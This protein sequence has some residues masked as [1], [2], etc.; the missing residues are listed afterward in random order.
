MP[1]LIGLAGTAGSGKD[2]TAQFLVK[3]HGFKAFAFADA[4][5]DALKIVLAIEDKYFEYPLKEVVIQKYG[6][7]AR[8][9]MQ[10][11]GTDWGRNSVSE[12]IWVDIAIN[13]AWSSLSAGSNVVLTDVRFENEANKIRKLGGK[14]WHIRRPGS[15]TKHFHE[16]E[17][18]IATLPY[19][20]VIANHSGL[21]NLYEDIETI[22]NEQG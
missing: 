6:K 10:A 17:S 3:Q 20:Y 11:L 13:K 22:L 18:G 9:L 1:V 14:I 12:D 4:V 21:E 7:S 8:E 15:G 5:R 2:T 19:D 16:S